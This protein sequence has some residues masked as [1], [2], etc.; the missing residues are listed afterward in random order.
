MM[1]EEQL[2]HLQRM[3]LVVGGVL[4]L[5]NMVESLIAATIALHIATPDRVVFTQ[6]IL[7]H[8]TMIDFVKKGRLVRAISRDV[9]G[10]DFDLND[11][12]RIAQVR[13]GLAHDFTMASLSDFIRNNGKPTPREPGLNIR[14]LE[15]N[16][17]IKELP[18]AAAVEECSRLMGVMQTKLFELQ[19]ILNPKESL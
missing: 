17:E 19:S 8:N 12:F 9:G 15:K 1:D 4:D 11:F 6:E 10:P 2:K 14:I 18:R 3:W 13:N 5:Y 7:L 16:C